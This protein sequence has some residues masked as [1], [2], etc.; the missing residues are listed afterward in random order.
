M[1]KVTVGG[2]VKTSIVTAFTIAAALIWKDV[3]E[4]LIYLFFPGDVFLYKFLAAIIATIFVIVAIYLVLKT[5]AE[6]ESIIKTIRN[7]NKTKKEKVMKE[8]K[9]E[10]EKQKIEEVKQNLGDSENK[11]IKK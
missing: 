8:I 5:E 9:K 4:E 11:E 7:M 6:A 3:I 1:S 2:I 10:Q